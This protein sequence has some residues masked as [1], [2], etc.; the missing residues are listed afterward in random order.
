[1][2]LS[3][4]SPQKMWTASCRD[5]TR[6][7]FSHRLRIGERIEPRL[8]VFCHGVGIGQLLFQ[9]QHRSG[10]LDSYPHDASDLAMRSRFVGALR[11]RGRDAANRSAAM[12]STHNGPSSFLMV[13]GAARTCDYTAHELTAA[14]SVNGAR[15]RSSSPSRSSI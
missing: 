15:P 13:G 14:A 7:L 8:A 11:V 4:L 1:M 5:T 2:F 12:R 3:I 9:W 10:L 6:T